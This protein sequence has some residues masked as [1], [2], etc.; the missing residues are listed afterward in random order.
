MKWIIV[1]WTST[2]CYSNKKFKSYEDAWDFL[3]CEYPNDDDALGEYYVI[4][5]SKPY[6]ELSLQ[7]RITGMFINQLNK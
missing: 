3:Y 4:K 2:R 6:R 5:E 7:D 1:D